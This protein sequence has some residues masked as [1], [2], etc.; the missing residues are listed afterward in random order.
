MTTRRQQSG[1]SILEALVAIVILSIGVLGVAGMNLMSLRGTQDSTARSVASQLAYEI[2]EQIR[3][4]GAGLGS[5]LNGANA[6]SNA[7]PATNCATTAATCTPAQQ[8][9]FDL[10]IW[11]RSIN[12]GTPETAKLPGGQAAICRDNTPNDGTPAAPSC[13]NGNFDPITIKIWW[14]ERSMNQTET[15]NAGAAVIRRQFSMSFQP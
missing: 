3:A 1:F 10:S 2:A 5:Y 15:A 11:A 7:A 8:A 13:S 14:N 6:V 12:A 9:A 4:N